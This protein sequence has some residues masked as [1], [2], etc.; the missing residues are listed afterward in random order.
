MRILYR[1][2][3]IKLVVHRILLI[4]SL[5]SYMHLYAVISNDGRTDDMNEMYT[6]RL[7]CRLNILIIPRE[8]EQDDVQ[9]V[10]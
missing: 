1:L 7:F 5:A 6:D 2:K 10:E 4:L 9:Y 3:C 8:V